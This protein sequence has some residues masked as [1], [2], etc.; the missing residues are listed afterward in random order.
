VLSDN[1]GSK[2]DLDALRLN[3]SHPVFRLG[4]VSMSKLRLSSLFL[5]ILSFQYSV[6]SALLI[7]HFRAR[8]VSYPRSELV[9][10]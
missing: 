8:W 1:N 4:L 7:S 9:L 10:K 3:L 5:I 6:F 2:V